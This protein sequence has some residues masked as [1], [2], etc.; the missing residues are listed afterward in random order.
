MLPRLRAGTPDL[1][2]LLAFSPPSARQV[3]AV[4]GRTTLRPEPD[5]VRPGA[6]V[7]RNPH[8]SCQPPGGSKRP[9]TG[10]APLHPGPSAQLEGGAPLPGV[11]HLCAHPPPGTP[12]SA[13][14]AGESVDSN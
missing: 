5:E 3:C 13:P 12:V 4:P 8:P 9:Y 1:P 6:A 10:A 2:G 11:A 14:P 7:S